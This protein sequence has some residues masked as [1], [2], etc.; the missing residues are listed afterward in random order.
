M[1]SELERWGNLQYQI[2]QP[3]L[4][5]KSNAPKHITVCQKDQCIPQKDRVE[6][7]TVC[8]CGIPRCNY[9]HQHCP[10]CG[11]SGC[12]ARNCPRWRYM[13]SM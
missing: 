12:R 1:G 2:L 10:L 13:H 3:S 4:G 9:M 6:K 7:F 5:V 11:S 8:P